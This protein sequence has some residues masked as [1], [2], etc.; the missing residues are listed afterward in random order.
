MSN[1]KNNK[2]NI[3]KYKDKINFKEYLN[4]SL[5]DLEFDDAIEKDKRKFCEIFIDLVKENHMIIKTFFIYDNIKIIIIKILL[6]I[7]FL[8]LYF[9]INALMYNEEYISEIYH[10]NKKAN[11]FYFLNNSIERIISVSIIG[12]VIGAFIEFFFV[13]EKKLKYIFMKAQNNDCI[14]IKIAKLINS[15]DK[16]YKSFISMS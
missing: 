6:F 13:D 12:I 15:I 10:S 8:D 16:K 7:I 11:F 9:V 1:S 4:T 3:I 14:K 2:K 5:D